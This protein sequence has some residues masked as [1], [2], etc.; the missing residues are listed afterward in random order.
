MVIEQVSLPVQLF[1]GYDEVGYAMGFKPLHFP[2][3]FRESLHLVCAQGVYVEAGAEVVVLGHQVALDVLLLTEPP[4]P[5]EL[6]E[7]RDVQGLSSSPL[8]D[9]IDGLPH[10]AGVDQRLFGALLLDGGLC[11]RGKAA[12]DDLVLDEALGYHAD[13]L[14]SL[15]S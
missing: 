13:L 10:G 6:V 7:K 15:F 11:V 12:V 8:H 4:D 3:A 14:E 9:K 5:V 1:V 2:L